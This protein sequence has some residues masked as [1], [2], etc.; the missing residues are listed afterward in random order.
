MITP[1]VFGD[2]KF[3]LKCEVVIMFVAAALIGYAIGLMVNS[4]IG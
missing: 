4:L 3:K 1:F 2:T